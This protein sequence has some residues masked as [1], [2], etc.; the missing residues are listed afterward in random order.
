[1]PCRATT[2]GVGAILEAHEIVLLAWG[3]G[4]AAVVK[5]MTEG[6]TS[7]SVPATYL[8]QH[9]RVRVVHDEAASAELTRV[10]TPWPAGTASDWR[11]P[12]TVR[13]A[14]TWLARHLKK[15][16][17]KLTD[18]QYNEH[19]LLDLLAASGPAYSI[20]IKVFNELQHT[21][22]GWPGARP[23][24]TT[25]TGPSAPRRPASASSGSGPRSATAPRPSSTTKSACPSTGP[26]RRS[27]A[28]ISES[29]RGPVEVPACLLRKKLR[30]AAQL[31]PVTHVIERATFH[32]QPMFI[33]LGGAGSEAF[34]M[35]G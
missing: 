16:I 4:K 28:G 21:I 13:K 3:E 32:R 34:S 24:P 1:M 26:S 2:M 9:P 19:G 31:C 30:K 22:T 7:D 6:E 35:T 27:C 33:G 20:N 10:K 25:P 15:P 14:V 11:Q 8:Q 29:R 18:E 23:G 12:A 17:L 5:R